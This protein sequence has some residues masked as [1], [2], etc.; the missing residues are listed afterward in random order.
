MSWQKNKF[1]RIFSLVA[2]VLLLLG[3][4]FMFEGLVIILLV[5]FLMFVG[6]FILFITLKE[7]ERFDKLLLLGCGGFLIYTLLT[8]GIAFLGWG[9]FD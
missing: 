8:F 7:R 1:F 5:G 6:Q 9:S 2:I 4:K 3:F